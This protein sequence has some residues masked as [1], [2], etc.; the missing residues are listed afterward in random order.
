MDF[1]PVESAFAEAVAQGVFPG[2]VVLVSKD[3]D[4]VFEQAF[5]SRSLV[6][7][8]TPLKPNTIF[9]L[10]S[11]T[12]PLA[13][14][15]AI[16]I[17]VRE[18]K[19][20]LDDQITRFIP[21]FGVFGKSS[22]TFRQMLNHSSGLPAWKPFHEEIVKMEKAGRINFVASRAA[23]SFVYEQIHREKPL[24]AP[25][26]QGL[27]SDLGFMILGESVEVLSNAMLE[28]FC[29]DRIFKPL[30]LRSTA[31][32]DLTQLRTRRLQP[33]EEM[34]APTEN[35]PWRKKILCGEVHDDNAYAMG[36][37]AGHAGLFSSARDIHALLAC[38]NRCLHG[39]DNF[40][41]KALLEEF[42]AKDEKVPNS[43]CALGW[44]TPSPDKSASGTHFSPRSVGHLGFT[45]TSIWW[46][47]EKNCHIILLSNRVHPTRKN[48]KIKDFRPHVHDL[49]MNVMFP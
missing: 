38:L 49:I 47:I 15:V 5:G 8:K 40:L 24:S 26:A 45:G 10:A 7:E 14:T 25:G 27:Y 48:E 34:I 3:G 2:A 22:A 37:V 9:D 31:F 46:D 43:T 30:G 35:C 28:R 23:K 21:M 20:R 4:I 18:K 1:H 32:V 33:V 41:P 44:D 29:Q 42:L 12:K 17:L 11:L 13:T 36:G 39:K 19:I 6:P 16:M